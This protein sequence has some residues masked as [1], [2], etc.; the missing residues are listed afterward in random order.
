MSKFKCQMNVKVKSSILK[1]VQSDTLV[2]PNLFRHL[3]LA[4][5]LI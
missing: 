4:L 1:G 2:M 5:G 3:A